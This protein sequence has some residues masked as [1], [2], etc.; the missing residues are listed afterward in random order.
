MPSLTH[1]R[2]L[3]PALILALGFLIGTNTALAKGLVQGGIAPLSLLLWHQA[4]AT[5]VLLLALV[6]RGEAFPRQPAAL[7]YSAL[8]GLCSLTLPA[9]IGFHAMPHI[10][11]GTYTAMYTLSPICTFAL[12]WAIDRSYPGH[13]RLLGLMVGGLGAASLVV[14]GLSLAP[15]AGPW[16]ALA[17]LTPLLLASGNL[18]RERLLPAGVSRLQLSAAQ[19]V[20]QL[21][22][23]V[24][25]ALL[26]GTP[27]A[28][29]TWPLD[30]ADAVLASQVVIACA[31]YPLFFAL[32]ARADA[33]A[34]SQIGYV[35]V[36]VGVLWGAGLYGEALSAW[37]AVAV[38]LLLAGL[39]L[40]QSAA[41]ATPAPPA[42]APAVRPCP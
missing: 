4:G 17:L 30:A 1:T 10:G 19:P 12:R 7:A 3:V 27:M 16:L 37:M 25:L 9:A 41:R 22:L 14:A 36:A 6:L 40:V 34:L 35:T 28:L 38:L 11:A 20:A 15:G 2:W 33:V 24:P 13:R 5:A 26:T 31:I 32:Q 29:P 21:A 39:H 42:A 18:V 8:L 23:L